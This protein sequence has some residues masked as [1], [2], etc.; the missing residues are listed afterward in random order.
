MEPEEM[1]RTV[2]KEIE[3]CLTQ[4]KQMPLPP[5]PIYESMY[6]GLY[7]YYFISITFKINN[8]LH[9]DIY[10]STTEYYIK[11]LCY[12]ILAPCVPVSTIVNTK[13][14]G[15]PLVIVQ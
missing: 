14:D 1:C 5:F 10:Y 13:Y 9:C 6:P 15:V 12:D 4:I 3:E 7:C 8:N 11:V 2:L